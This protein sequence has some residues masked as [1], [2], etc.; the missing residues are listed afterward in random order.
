MIK[1]PAIGRKSRAVWYA[2]AFATTC[3]YKAVK[4][5]IEKIPKYA[6]NATKFAPAMGGRA[7]I[8]SWSIGLLALRS[9]ARNTSPVTAATANSRMIHQVP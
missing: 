7:N 4:K 5:K 6:A 8:D 2:D 3:K 1:P 9:Y